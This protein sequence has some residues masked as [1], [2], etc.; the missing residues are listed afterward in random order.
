M[1]FKHWPLTLKVVS[2]L[3]LLA[4]FSFGAIIYASLQ[5]TAINA[6]G[7]AIIEGPAP[8]IANLARTNRLLRQVEIGIW[9]LIAGHTPEEDADAK[10]LI[11]Q[12]L[13]DYRTRTDLIQA[14]APAFAA[15][16]EQLVQKVQST[17]AGDC[18]S[19]M[20]EAA[21]A[22]TAD[23]IARV[24]QVMRT[25]CSPKIDALANAT[26][27]INKKLTAT[28]EAENAAA[29]ALAHQT[30]WLLTIGMAVGTVLVIG[31]A[32]LITRRSIVAPVTD[33]MSVMTALGHG[34]LE[35]QVPH[36]DRRDEVGAIANALVELR[37]KLQE[38][39]RQRIAQAEAEAVA[40]AQIVRRSKLAE[41][42]VSRIQNLV[43]GFVHSSSD[44]ADAARNLSATAE[45]TSRQAQA[46]A[47]ASE[48]AS[49][50]VQTVAS[51]SEEMAA[52]VREING[53]VAHSAAVADTAFLEAKTS[54]T[55]IG[56]LSKAAVDIGD[57][58]GLIKDIA[59]QTNL[60]AL[61][62]TIEAAR[63]GEAG[64]GFAVVASEVKQLAEQTAK[65]TD[66]I[67]D[68]IAEIRQATD[69]TVDSMAEIIR[70]IT[71]IKETA[72]AIAGA[73]EEQGVATAEI[74]QNCQQAATGTSEV[75][76][77]ITG[78]GQAA[79]M[80][81]GASTQLMTLS[82][83]LSAQAS[84]LRVVVDTFVKDLAAA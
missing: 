58:L 59:A 31:L 6:V 81:G 57:V 47:A 82:T 35:V 49:T 33:S 27:G 25:T 15:E 21:T 41:D 13:K 30:A 75:A 16:M 69:S 76:Q 7:T 40:K 64:R 8:A 79:E 32:V 67:S 22:T 55:H 10:Q 12:V 56:A 29:V 4:I 53:Q 23:E 37:A 39:A 9:R 18:G 71:T 65:A 2:L 1:S 45:E 5:M 14:E 34:E 51:A 66:E 78:V 28:M 11:E 61:N 48:Q 63:A 19:V 73:V 26:T 62:A 44:V 17:M 42:F 84:D 50:N 20:R 38:A 46:V 83:G 60:L 72:T 80:T 74:A 24:D 68:K 52:S 43:A 36:T 54:N 3:L 77:N 70:V